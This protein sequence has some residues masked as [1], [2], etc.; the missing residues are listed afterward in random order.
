MTRGKATERR[1]DDL[2]AQ[3]TLEEK[4]AMCH[5][6]TA[7]S[8]AGVPRLGIPDLTMSDGP[9]G[10][11]P[12]GRH[13][14]AGRPPVD[15]HMTALPPGICLAAAWNTDLAAEFGR[16]L[17]AESRAR[18]K[19]VILGPAINIRR[20]PLC[21]RNFEYY[22]EDPHLAARL[23]VPCVR[24]I[25]KQ[26]TAACVKHYA[27]N[28]Q[29]LARTRVDTLP[30]ER[31][32][33]EIYLPA[34]EAAVREGNAL[35]VMGAYNKVRGQHCCHNDYLLNRVLK[36]EWGFR[37]AVMSDWGGT[38]DT[39]EAA[40]CGLDIEMGTG[41]EPAKAWLGDAYLDGLRAGRYAVAELDDKVRRIL[42]VM[43]AIG[44]LGG[45]RPRGAMNRP[46]HQRVARAVAAEGLVLLKNETGLLPLDFSRIRALAVIG[47]NADRPHC[48]GGG[49]S[50]VRP[51]Y[52]I[53][54]LH[55][56]QTRFGER[57]RI[58]HE[59]GY[60][61]E[62]ATRIPI[63][64]E[65][66]DVTG[67]AGGL[68]GWTLDW[69]NTR[70]GPHRDPPVHTETVANVDFASPTPPRPDFV[71]RHYA[72]R[73]VAHLTAPET[74]SYEFFLTGME[75]GLEIDQR[76]V[77]GNWGA[78]TP[79]T[80]CTRVDLQAGQ[81][82]RLAVHAY[83]GD[84]GAEVHLGWRTPSAGVAAPGERFRRAVALAREADVVL[85][86][87]GLNHGHDTEGHDLP[88]T[89][90]L[91]GQDE[92]IAALAEANPRTVVVLCGSGAL[93]MPWLDRVPAVLQAWYPGMEGGNA[94]VDI[95]A[96]DVNP[97][98]K[99]PLTMARRLEDCPAH[100][101]GDYND[102]RVGYREGVFVGY[103]H[104][105]AAGVEPLFPFGHGLSYTRFAFANPGVAIEGRGRR[106]RATVAFDVANA[107]PRA[108]AEVAQLYLRD[109][110]CSLP[111]PP[112][113]LKGF[114]KIALNPGET[115]RVELPLDYR[116]LAFYDPV[117]RAWR[118]EPG[119]FTV[120][121]GASSRD[122]RLSAGFRFEG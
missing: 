27:C 109:E 93:E 94:L 89:R 83:P 51:L 96:G 81:R 55:A 110:Q 41:G 114:R 60:P 4:V 19:D 116:S 90:A 62:A 25:Q 63:P 54:L 102:A 69:F 98:G 70:A 82:Y 91:F 11:A 58:V 21:G 79:T 92:L 22:G 49:S 66:L 115:A 73:W 95:L 34:F 43:L 50:A 53:T 33:R 112:R 74:G 3:M 80:T 14:E 13:P 67:G 38:H 44:A 108:G 30:D 57:L 26:G 18:G 86:A 8:S 40:T 37:G 61:D 20:T 99:L 105:D 31:T 104:H 5:A 48:V 107:G 16:V 97:S 117:Q 88:G 1:I 100:R 47:D 36:D 120:E 7:F 118:A 75:I 59:P 111:R 113:E 56:L 87:G 122:I 106:F 101:F 10:V 77:G 72:L 42:R 39:F 23:A 24:A 68:R 52:E 85:F 71:P 32:L 35:T 121:I 29:E 65:S 28:N 119:D 2:I 64:T 76:Y 6:K 9:H 78:D 45:R 103:R 15:D 12:E 17:G 84:R 46:D